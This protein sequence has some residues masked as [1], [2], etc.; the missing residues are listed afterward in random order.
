MFTVIMDILMIN[1]DR[2]QFHQY[3]QP[4]TFARW[5]KRTATYDLGNLDPGMGHAQK[6]RGLN[7][8]IRS[9][10]APLYD[11]MFSRISRQEAEIH[12]VI[13]S[14]EVTVQLYTC[15]F[16]WSSSLVLCTLCCQ[17]LWI[18]HSW[19]RLW[20]S[21]T[22]TLRMWYS[23]FNKKDNIKSDVVILPLYNE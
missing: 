22:L 14:N 12:I 8:L 9:H 15:L 18:V 10:F 2:Q 7:H 20:F 4:F 3:Q 1:S 19:L 13:F 11:H 23:F 21:L 6:W 5:T 17:C 16:C